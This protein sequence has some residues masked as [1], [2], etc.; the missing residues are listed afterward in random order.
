MKR[1]VIMLG[2][3][4]SLFSPVFAGVALHLGGTAIVIIVA[5]CAVVTVISMFKK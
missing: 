5:I 2:L 4:A 3:M 1:V